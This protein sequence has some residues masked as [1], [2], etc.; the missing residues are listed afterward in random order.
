MADTAS[1]RGEAVDVSFAVPAQR[2][3][4]PR[5]TAHRIDTSSGIQ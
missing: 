5:D 3:I 2:R 4:Y 1:A